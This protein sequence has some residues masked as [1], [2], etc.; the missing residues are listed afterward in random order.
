MLINNTIINFLT[1]I[2]ILVISNH[3]CFRVLF[4]KIGSVY[5]ILK[6]YFY[7]SIGNGQPWKPALCQLYRHTFVPYFTVIQ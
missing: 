5:V 6:I 3:N 2:I 4:D 1:A 7:F